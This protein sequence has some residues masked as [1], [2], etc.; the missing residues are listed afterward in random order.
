[1][2][3]HNSRTIKALQVLPNGLCAR[4]SFWTPNKC[5]T[6]TRPYST[7][8]IQHNC[9]Q[10]PTGWFH[11]VKQQWPT[12]TVKIAMSQWPLRNTTYAL[13]NT[14]ELPVRMSP[15]QSQD[16]GKLNFPLLTEV[17]LGAEHIAHTAPETVH[18]R[19]S[20]SMAVFIVHIG[21]ENKDSP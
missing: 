21:H 9:D 20:Q 13:P 18:N 11:M 14:S 6:E 15:L 12:H 17:L 16:L 19:A 4:H 8:A 7:N 10:S 5:T 3:S 1:M 2:S